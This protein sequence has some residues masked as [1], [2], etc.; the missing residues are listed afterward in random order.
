[1]LYQLEHRNDEF[2]KTHILSH[3]DPYRA[4]FLVHSNAKADH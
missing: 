1:M 4:L 2:E 3:R